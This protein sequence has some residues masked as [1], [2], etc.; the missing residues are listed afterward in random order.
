MFYILNL[1]VIRFINATV[2]HLK[3]HF[4]VSSTSSKSTF[5][6]SILN[7]T[8]NITVATG[9]EIYHG[10][11]SPAGIYIIYYILILYLFI[12]NKHSLKKIKKNKL[13]KNFN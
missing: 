13:I 7:P 10:T 5:S 1:N 11:P 2:S 12:E 3:I 6:P 9:I 8:N 4:V